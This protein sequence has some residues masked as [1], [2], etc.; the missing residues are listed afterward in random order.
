M[1]SCRRPLRELTN[2]PI[3]DQVERERADAA[4]L[5]KSEFLAKMSH[6]LRTPLNAVIGFAD[7]MRAGAYGTD[8]QRALSALPRGHRLQR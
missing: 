4:N 5:A 2:P 8:R 3:P 6:E 1:S 7:V